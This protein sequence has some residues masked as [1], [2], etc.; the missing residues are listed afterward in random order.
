[1]TAAPTAGA[2]VV[3]S[4]KSGAVG[5]EITLSASGLRGNAKVEIGLGP[6]EGE[7][8]VITEATTN[9]AGQANSRLV[10]PEWAKGEERLIFVVESE[11]VSVLSEPFE[12]TDN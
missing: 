1:M 5:D 3:L 8:T 7:Y 9:A 12:V 6:P 10:I 11:R 2:G 4:P